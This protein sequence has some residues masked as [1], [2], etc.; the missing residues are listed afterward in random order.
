MRTIFVFIAVSVVVVSVTGC[1]LIANTA[2]C[3]R[4]S[5]CPSD[6]NACVAHQC[7]HSCTQDADCNAGDTCN[8]TSGACTP[9]PHGE[10]EGEGAP[11]EGEGA[12]EGEGEGEGGEGEGEGA[13]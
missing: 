5:Q 13:P 4:P 11:G 10:G 9:N 7:A 1:D 8:V 12:A 2:A 3:D 6:F